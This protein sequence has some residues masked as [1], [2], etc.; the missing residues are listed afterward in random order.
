MR[1]LH[2][3]P[4]AA[5]QSPRKAQPRQ[6]WSFERRL[7]PPSS[8]LS[9][10]SLATCTQHPG[11][12][13]CSSKGPVLSVSYTAFPISASPLVQHRFRPL[14]WWK[15][16]PLS[17]FPSLRFLPRGRLL[18]FLSS[19][20]LSMIIV[21]TSYQKIS[22]SQPS[23]TQNTLWVFLV[24]KRT[25]VLD[26]QISVYLP[27]LDNFHSFLICEPISRTDWRSSP[28]SREKTR[29]DKTKDLNTSTS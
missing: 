9:G 17:P 4:R 13:G 7:L 1:A 12:Q 14:P 24:T 23:G 22:R 15:L 27:M 8:T 26:T 29:Q 25:Q 11:P 19:P 5:T 2:Y 18:S 10:P 3:L 16:K 6:A 21:S 20:S 28:C